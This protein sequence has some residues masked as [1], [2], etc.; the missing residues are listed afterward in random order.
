[1]QASREIPHLDKS[2][3]QA[4]HGAFTDHSHDGLSTQVREP[5][6][7]EPYSRR[8]KAGSIAVA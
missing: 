8:Y 1:M 7:S 3:K 4:K 2:I 6:S 5:K